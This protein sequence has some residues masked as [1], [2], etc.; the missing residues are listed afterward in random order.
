MAC[1]TLKRSYDFDPVLSP[2]QQPCKKRRRYMA[3][4]S[5]PTTSTNE[6]SNFLDVTPKMTSGEQSAKELCKK[7][8]F[9]FA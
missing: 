1:A 9:I 2:Q 3:V 7:S 4:K 5:S 6:P 8:T